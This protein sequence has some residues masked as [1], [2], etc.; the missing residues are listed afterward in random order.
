[1][2]VW[3]FLMF[4]FLVACSCHT[5]Q[6]LKDIQDSVLENYTKCLRPLKNQKNTMFVYTDLMLNSIQDFNVKTGTLKSSIALNLV[7]KDEFIQWDALDEDMMMFQL[8]KDK[9][10]TPTMILHNP[11]E[12]FELTT[13]STSVHKTQHFFN[14][15]V[16]YVITGSILTLCEP[17]IFYYPMDKHSCEIQIINSHY[18][19][20]VVLKSLRDSIRLDH[21]VEHP[22][23][24]I[25]GTNVSSKFVH[26]KITEISFNIH[27]RR[28]PEFLM[29]NVLLPIIFLSALNV[30]VFLLPH[31]SGERISYAITLLLTFVVFMNAMADELPPIGDPVCLLNIYITIQMTMSSF[32][33]FFTIASLSLYDNDDKAKPVPTHWKMCAYYAGKLMCLKFKSVQEFE[34]PNIPKINEVFP[35]EDD[36]S[37]VIQQSQAEPYL[38]LG[39][40]DIGHAVDRSLFVVSSLILI[41]DTSFYFWSIFLT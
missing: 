14:G 10:W 13:E 16:N 18:E 2:A 8:S 7:W 33:V 17:D 9:V 35:Y 29:I 23:W 28:K 40:K 22:Q 5:Y 20:K 4:Y 26:G 39:W 32:I 21:Y 37:E 34:I 31:Q 19:E 6:V 3:L 30:L 11:A 41:C 38:D 36:D 1:M 15:T 24:V 12:G 27:F 25:T